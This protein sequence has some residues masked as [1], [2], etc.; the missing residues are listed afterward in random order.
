MKNDKLFFGKNELKYND[1]ITYENFELKHNDYLDNYNI[2]ET[3]Y[4]KLAHKSTDYV[5]DMRD[6]GDNV[7]ELKI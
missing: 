5:G 6:L 4:N 7:L 1:T 2:Y 3:S